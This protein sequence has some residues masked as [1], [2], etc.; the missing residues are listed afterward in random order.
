VKSSDLN[1]ES[2][3]REQK[4][5]TI[6]IAYLDG[7]LTHKSPTNVFVDIG[8]LAYDVQISLNTYAQL[9]A[10]HQVKLYTHLIVREDAHSLYGF[11]TLEEKELFI[12]LISVSG[13]GPNTARVILSYMTS[14]EAVGAILTDNVLAFN[15]VKGVGPKT[16]QRIILDLKDKLAK[17]DLGTDIKLTVDHHSIREEALSALQALGFQKNII[18]KQIDKAM[19][20]NSDIVQVET[21][22]K[23]VLK[24]LS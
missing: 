21:L 4:R 16:A 8:G 15:K 12:K 13:I 9:E 7:K 24:Q 20:N 5:K 14:N 10:L 6:L 22:I 17:T 3:R 18:T 19:S 1:V 2:R 23:A 11:F